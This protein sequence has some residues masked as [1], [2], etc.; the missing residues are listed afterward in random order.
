MKLCNTLL[1]ISAVACLGTGLLN[2][3]SASAQQSPKRIDIAAKRFN[4]TP[5]EV[6]LKKGEAVMLVFNS[7]DTTHGIR[8]KELGV[9]TKVSKG[10]P[11]EVPL[12]PTQT[13]DFV[14][15]CS[16]FCGTGHGG[17]ALTI[18]VVE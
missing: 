17:M 5:G 9:D 4:F 2:R 15:Q 18:H 14:G 13:G 11:T 10:R 8:F 6:T 12:T 16:V 7:S 1:T 3:P